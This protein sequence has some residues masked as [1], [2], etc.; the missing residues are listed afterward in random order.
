MTS[1][2]SQEGAAERA[3]DGILRSLDSYISRELHREGTDEVDRHLETCAACASELQS[4]AMLKDRLRTAVRQEIAPPYL[5]VR[6]RESIRNE[7]RKPAFAFGWVRWAAAAAAV[8]V[9]S[10]GIWT[11]RRPEVLP[12]L[13]DRPAQDAFI[14]RVSQTISTVL[15]VG[16]G[17]HLHCSVFRK[18]P[19]NPPSLEQMATSM[20]PYKD[21]IGL[22]K[23]GVP[24]EY[25]LLMAHQCG[26]AGR[27]FVHLTLSNPDG[28]LL[29]VVITR[30]N[31]G[32][33]LAG[34]SPIAKPGGIPLYQS[35]THNYKVAGFDTAQYLAFVISE[36]GEGTN[37]QFAENLAPAIHEFLTKQG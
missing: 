30:K 2:H 5:Q 23:A 31:P 35:S 32:E 36:L 12:A 3:C 26:Y 33:T 24:T 10:T 6:I 29:S 27:R 13:N 28:K 34:L 22:V 16:L 25:R 17:D 19:K 7:A 4:R 15:R 9:V 20:G 37:L 21:L 18:Y 8:L 14:R 1:F 11:L